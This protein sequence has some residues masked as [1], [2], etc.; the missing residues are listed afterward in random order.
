[1]DTFVQVLGGSHRTLARLNRGAPPLQA[2]TPHPFPPP[3]LR[4]WAVRAGSL[5]RSLR[6]RLVMAATWPRAVPVTGEIG[7]IRC[8]CGVAVYV[9]SLRG[10]CVYASCALVNDVIS[11]V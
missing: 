11:H 6:R 5:R 1:M 3:P 9:W 2:S 8:V 10:R 4:G 7:E